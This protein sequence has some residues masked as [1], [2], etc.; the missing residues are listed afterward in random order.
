MLHTFLGVDDIFKLLDDPNGNDAVKKR[1]SSTSLAFTLC[2][3]G[4]VVAGGL[5]LG[6]LYRDQLLDGMFGRYFRWGR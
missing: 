4:L 2:I 3:A 5:A 1:G 6:W